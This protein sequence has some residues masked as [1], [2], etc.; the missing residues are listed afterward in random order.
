MHL[1]QVVE[2]SCLPMQP[3]DSALDGIITPD[4]VIETHTPYPQPAG[5]DWDAV[6]PDQIEAI[7][8]LQM[9]REQFETQL[10]NARRS[11]ARPSGEKY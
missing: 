8:V 9:L 7:P 4:E 5:L 1:L 10:H 2:D 11:S 3:H 6:R